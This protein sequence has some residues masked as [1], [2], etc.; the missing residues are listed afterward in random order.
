MFTAGS[1]L[2][3]GLNLLL[4]GLLEARVQDRPAQ[5]NLQLNLIATLIING[6]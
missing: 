2:V 6:S 4:I 5:L 1:W 3:S